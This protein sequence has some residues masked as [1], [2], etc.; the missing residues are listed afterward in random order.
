MKILFPI[1]ASLVISTAFGQIKQ[2]AETLSSQA[3]PAKVTTTPLPTQ[4]K[5]ED[6]FSESKELD[7]LVDAYYA[8]LTPSQRVAQLLMPAVGKYGQD[9]AKIERLTREGKIGGVLML[10]GSKPQFTSWIENFNAI[11]D[12][13]NY[14]PFLYSADAEPSLINRKITGTPTIQKANT[15]KTKEE[16]VKCA[17]EISNELNDIGIN[18]NFAPVVDM[19][20]NKTVGWRS[21]GHEPDSVISWSSAFIQQTQQNNILATAKHFPGHGFVTG[22][23]HKQLVYIDGELK[24]LHNYPQLIEE[25]VMSIMVAHIAIKNNAVYNTNDMPST[26]SKAVVTDLLR[27]SL[28]FEGLIITDAMN[29]GGVRNVKDAEILA[30]QA[31]CDIL[32]MPLDADLA[33]KKLLA[34]YTTD[35]NFQAQVELACKRII[36]AKIAMGLMNQ[37]RK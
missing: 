11:N 32:L 10:N 14:L 33:H 23:T 13:L 18:Y 5:M 26:T 30:I 25:G 1:A 34:L 6:F 24:E 12:S 35:E 27:D 7:S 29:M 3:L 20:P 36:R 37:N 19:S 22:D 21:F 17:Q 16:V 28:G 15:L 31:G 4:F 9:Y 2:N 8:Q